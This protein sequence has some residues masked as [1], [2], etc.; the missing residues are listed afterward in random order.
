M[1]RTDPTR[2]R[3]YIANRIQQPTRSIE[4]SLKFRLGQNLTGGANAS[5]ES[6]CQILISTG[7]ISMA[8]GASNC[9]FRV[10]SRA[11]VPIARENN[12]DNCSTLLNSCNRI[13]SIHSQ[14]TVGS[15]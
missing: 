11:I 15:C 12:W 9:N 10:E 3:Q 13:S 14:T 8:S 1:L 5:R 2:V 7:T 6:G 4:I